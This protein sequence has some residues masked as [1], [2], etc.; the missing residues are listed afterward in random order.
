MTTYPSLRQVVVDTRDARGSAE[1]YRELF[2]LSYQEGD[3]PPSAGQ[4]DP[5]G[6]DWLV[7]TGG[8]SRPRIAFQQVTDLP[9]STWP[10]PGVPQQLHLDF[11]VGSVDE[12]ERHH[13]RVLDAG[14]T[15]RL[16]RADDP[17]EPLRA[18]ADPSG[19]PFCVFV[20]PA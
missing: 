2:G 4:P 16:D 10:D 13:R 7:L 8:P 19:H 17:E 18:Y 15:L 11:C 20:L 1:F 3:E 6:E 14:G 9:A 5:K 12:L